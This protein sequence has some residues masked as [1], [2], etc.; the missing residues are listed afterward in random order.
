MTEGAS[1]AIV[2]TR[3]D[4]LRDAYRSK[5]LRQGGYDEGAVVTAD[6]R[7]TCMAMSTGTADAWRTSSSCGKRSAI[8]NVTSCRR[9]SPKW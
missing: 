9:A 2:L 6:T 8:T 7:W 4:D 1:Q 3:H 5:D